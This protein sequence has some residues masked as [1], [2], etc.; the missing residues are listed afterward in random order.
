LNKKVLVDFN[1]VSSQHPDIAKEASGWDPGSK[2]ATSHEKVEWQCEKSHH[3]VAEIRTR[4]LRKY[5]CPYCAG[6]RLIV[7]VNDI[8]SQYPEIASQAFG[9]DPHQIIRSSNT[10]LAWKCSLGH[11]WKQSPN[12]RKVGTA[13]KTASGCP[14]CANQ[15]VLTGFNDLGT[16]HSE[17]ASEA[18]GWDPTK[19]TQGHTGKKLWICKYRH[20]WSASINSRAHGRGCPYCY[21]RYAIPGENDFVTKFPELA[22]QSLDKIPNNETKYSPKRYRWKCSNEHVWQASLAQ[23]TKGDGC[24][25]CSGKKV[26]VGF[27]DLVTTDPVLAKQAFNWDPTEVS[28]G[29]SKRRDW[30]CARGHIWRTKVTSRILWPKSDQYSGCPICSGQQV[31]AG[32]NDLATTDPEIARQAVNWDPR[33][34]SRMSQKKMNWKCDLGHLF[35]SQISNRVLRASGPNCPVC[36]GKVIL[37]GFNDLLSR[38]PAVAA[39]ADGW[40]PTEVTEFANKIRAWKCSFGHTWKTTVGNRS[41]GFGCPSCAKYGYDPNEKAW[42]Y[43]LRHAEL[44]L[45]QIGITNDPKARLAKHSRAGWELMELKGPMDGFLTREWESNILEYLSKQG[46]RLRP[47]DVSGKFDGY[48]EAWVRTS[49]SVESLTSLMEMVRD[50]EMN[51]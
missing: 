49:F 5:G 37:K 9:W 47:S 29:A 45:L 14:V 51:S 31:L 50:S 36:A 2:V 3:W 46:A 23:R 22:S 35:R 27:N 26:L 11:E 34:V 24:P 19:F 39:Q 44:D 30:Q 40:D 20:Q 6:Q 13:G 17:L 8:A 21:G 18:F 42:L 25:Y 33:T 16:T 32:F 12:G 38:N 7:G 15:K 28:R 41:Y 4:T 48:T 43:F 10:K 1:D